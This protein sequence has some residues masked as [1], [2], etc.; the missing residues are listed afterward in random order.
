MKLRRQPHAGPE[1][2]AKAIAGLRL[3]LL[4][5]LSATIVCLLATAY[6]DPSPRAAIALPNTSLCIHH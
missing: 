3:V 2:V 1:A 5:T 6:F 4:L